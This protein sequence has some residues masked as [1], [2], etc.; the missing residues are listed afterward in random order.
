MKSLFDSF[1]IKSEL[2]Y[3][4]FNKS[5][6]FVTLRGTLCKWVH[7]CPVSRFIPFFRAPQM[8]VP[9]FH[10]LEN[11]ELPQGAGNR[12]TG[13]P[14]C[15]NCTLKRGFSPACQKKYSHSPRAKSAAALAQPCLGWKKGRLPLPAG[16]SCLPRIADCLLA[17]RAGSPVPP[18]ALLAGNGLGSEWYAPAGA[19]RHSAPDRRS[20][21]LW[22]AS[23]LQKA[24]TASPEA[25]AAQTP[26]RHFFLKARI[27]PS[28]C[29]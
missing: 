27:A 18:P 12:L 11:R 16:F 6:R 4:I 8:H 26:K 10:P 21:A 20:P 25:V 14:P 22:R 24:A 13:L 17:R 9:A 15:L 5:A 28:K 19:V 2:I 1:G 29:L 7:G 3:R 23:A